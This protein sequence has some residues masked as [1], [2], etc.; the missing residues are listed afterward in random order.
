MIKDKVGVTLIK[1]MTRE[2]RPRWFGHVRKRSLDKLVRRC[3]RIVLSVVE[4]N[5]VDLRKVRPK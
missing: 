2:A 4:G 1:D 3:E 5:E